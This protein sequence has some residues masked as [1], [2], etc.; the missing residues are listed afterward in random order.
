[1][2]TVCIYILGLEYVGYEIA[3]CRHD[4]KTTFTL[5]ALCE[6]NPSINGGFSLK[7]G[8]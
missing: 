8:Q 4:M 1:M 2:K 5:L 7:K 6:G 3:W